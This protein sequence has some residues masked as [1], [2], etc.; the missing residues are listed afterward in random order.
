MIFDCR[1]ISL[2]ITSKNKLLRWYI[3]NDNLSD[4]DIIEI[5]HNFNGDLIEIVCSDDSAFALT[6]NGIIYKLSYEHTINE[7]KLNFKVKTVACSSDYLIIVDEDNWLYSG[8]S[9]TN[10]QLGI[11][12]MYSHC[13]NDIYSTNT[14]LGPVKKIVCGYNFTMLFTYSNELFGW[15]S[16]E[17]KQLSLDG[18]NIL[19]P[20][21]I[22]S[23]YLEDSTII[24]ISCGHDYSVVVTRSNKLNILVSGKAGYLFDSS[25]ILNNLEILPNVDMCD[26]KC[27]SSGS[28]HTIFLEETLDGSKKLWGF[29]QKV[30]YNNI[31][32][33]LNKMQIIPITIDDMDNI[34]YV[35][36][37][38]WDV[39][40]ISNSNI[41][42]FQSNKLFQ[43]CVCPDL[44]TIDD[45]KI[46]ILSGR[47]D[48][49]INN[50]NKKSTKSANNK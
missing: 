26:L 8:G 22:N 32:H 44:T 36:C 39:F 50:K 18:T 25:P 49:P 10:G 28:F 30:N 35:V 15:G 48:L 33:Y 5:D 27:I 45:S 29:V 20:T 43:Y 4:K 6:N 11:G 16:N 34:E 24:D 3:N 31:Y 21:K 17:S 37:G 42:S 46:S 1:T 7:I 40:L 14:N 13:S 47:F 23:Q 9:N 41:Y 38:N 2:L 12:T 19:V